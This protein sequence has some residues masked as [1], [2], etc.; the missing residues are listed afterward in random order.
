MDVSPIVA[1]EESKLVKVDS[2]TTLAVDEVQEK[3]KEI[4]LIEAE[5]KSEGAISLKDYSQYFAFS[6]GCTGMVLY[7]V[8]GILASLA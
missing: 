4:N 2:K 5:K 1:K 3:K 8:I 7:W 6:T